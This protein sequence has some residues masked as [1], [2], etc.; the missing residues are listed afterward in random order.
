MAPTT[1][2][3]TSSG[4]VAAEWH[5]AD[6]DLELECD[7]DGTTEYNF[8]GPNVEEYEGPVDP[9]FEQLRQHVAMLLKRAE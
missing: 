2:I 3:P 8:A 1:I 7:L 4:G 6:Y 5:I 9:E